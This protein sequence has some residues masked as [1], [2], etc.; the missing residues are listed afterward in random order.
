MSKK[1]QPFSRRNSSWADLSIYHSPRPLSIA[2]TSAFKASSSSSHSQVSSISSPHFTHAPRTLRTLL[3]FAVL[4]LNVNV[5]NDL[6]CIASLHRM[7]AGLKCSRVGFYITTFWLTMNIPS[8]FFIPVGKPLYP[9]KISI[10]SF[11]SYLKSFAW[12]PLRKNL[13]SLYISVI[14]A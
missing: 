1:N 6:N 12:K 10:S 3:A 7:P 5:I 14:R 8:C 11:H 9:T 13:F 4:S 2:F